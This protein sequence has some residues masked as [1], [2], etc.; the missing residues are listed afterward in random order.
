SPVKDD[1]NSSVAQLRKELERERLASQSYR[2]RAEGREQTASALRAQLEARAFR[3]YF[4]ETAVKQTVETAMRE[5]GVTDPE[6]LDKAYWISKCDERSSFLI[7]G[8][9]PVDRA[10]GFLEPQWLCVGGPGISR[11]LTQWL[12]ETKTFEISSM[13]RYSVSHVLD[14]NKLGLSTG[15]S[16][17]QLL[18]PEA[19]GNEAAAAVAYRQM[20]P[21]SPSSP[22]VELEAQLLTGAKAKPEPVKPSNK[23][24]G[25]IVGTPGG[26]AVRTPGGGAAT[27]AAPATDAATSEPPSS[28]TSGA[29]A[30]NGA[31]A[32]SP[33]VSSVDFPVP[34]HQQ[35][36]RHNLRVAGV[37]AIRS[38][39]T[40]RRCRL[41]LPDAQRD[42]E[43]SDDSATPSP[44]PGA[45]TTQG[46][47]FDAERNQLLDD[48]SDAYRRIITCVGED[49]ERQGLRKTPER[50]AKAMLYFTK[51]Y[52]ETIADIL[53]DAVFDENHEEMVVVKDIEMFSMC[54]H[55]MVPFMGKV[56]I[57][58]LPNMRVLGISK[59]ARIVEVYSRRLQVQERLTKQI[60][61]ALMEAIRPAGVAVVVQA[62]HMCMVMRGVQKINAS[63]VTSSMLGV[64]REDT[65]IRDEF[66]NHV[67]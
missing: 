3:V 65:K 63:T 2:L 31:V 44:Q 20:H 22:T 16:S 56:S 53:N 46:A 12:F 54:E 19:A 15:N 23:P 30:S 49:T 60:A 34:R 14:S 40:P 9:G 50:A 13:L 25:N 35:N 6:K 41:R 58:Y 11:I 64:F 55:H 10:S 8:G 37:G 32:S 1:S 18:A 66:M 5:A 42:Y 4:D 33:A 52:E 48:M 43:F 21:M 59:L 67:K 7:P 57:G 28:A 61:L 24:R 26:V 45:L 39:D 29:A 51:G 47:Y 27:A 38:P 62:T 36:H 17:P